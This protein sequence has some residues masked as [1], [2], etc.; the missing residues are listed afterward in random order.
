MSICQNLY[1]FR[2]LYLLTYLG[3]VN[4]HLLECFI[5][6][7]VERF[8][9]QTNVENIAAEELNH[10]LRISF[11]ESAPLHHKKG[12][13]SNVI[14]AGIRI[15]QKCLL[16]SFDQALTG[17][18]KISGESFILFEGEYLKAETTFF[19]GN[20][21]TIYWKDLHLKFKSKLL[22][23]PLSINKADVSLNRLFGSCITKLI[24]L[25]RYFEI[26][27]CYCFIN[28][29]FESFQI[30]LVFYSCIEL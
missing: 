16:N 25:H 1:F 2:A 23:S 28:T 15:Q 24:L 14:R 22:V 4:V 6:C 3:I 27:K 9:V 30:N 7:S 12:G 18:Y 21:E 26:D 5:E 19:M 17:I 13:L 11:A 10:K 20:W 29:M 8:G